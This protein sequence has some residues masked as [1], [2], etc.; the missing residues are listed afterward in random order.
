MISRAAAVRGAL[1][2]TSAGLA[3]TPLSF[4]AE[5][6]VSTEVAACS[7]GTC[8]FEESSL[9]IINGIRTYN[10]YDK[11]SAGPCGADQ[12]LPPPGG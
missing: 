12:P 5:R 10:A 6:G 7:D 1:L 2:L 4:S 11:G 3:F 9:C 8:C